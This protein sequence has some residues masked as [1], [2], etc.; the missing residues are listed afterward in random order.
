M[1]LNNRRTRRVERAVA[2]AQNEHPQNK[3][4]LGFPKIVTD[5]IEKGTDQTTTHLFD[6]RSPY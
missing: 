5:K 6:T 4:K 2:S 1:P 3:W